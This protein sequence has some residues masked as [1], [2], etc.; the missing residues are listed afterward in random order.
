MLT[1]NS[2]WHLVNIESRSICLNSY[3]SKFQHTWLCFDFLSF[4]FSPIFESYIL[5]IFCSCRLFNIVLCAFLLARI[6]GV[7]CFYFL[8]FCWV[9]SVSAL[10]ASFIFNIFIYY[11]YISSGSVLFGF[12]FMLMSTIRQVLQPWKIEKAYLCRLVLLICGVK[13]HARNF[14]T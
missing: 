10:A 5:L 3:L 2:I 9:F 11:I 8:F 7:R 13:V 1:E 4:F 14:A 6:C 12:Y